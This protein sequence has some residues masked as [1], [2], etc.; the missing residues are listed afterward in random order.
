MC[1]NTSIKLSPKA[2]IFCEVNILLQIPGSTHYSIVMYFVTSTLK[3]GSL[4]QR[5]FDGDDEFRN[6]RL[7]L[8]PAVP[9]VCF[10]KQNNQAANIS[11]TLKPRF[12]PTNKNSGLLDSAAECRKYSLFTGKGRRLQLRAWFGVLG[13]KSCGIILSV[14][15][16][17]SLTCRVLVQNI[18]Y[19]RKFIIII[20]IFHLIRQRVL[21]DRLFLQVD[22][23]I[24]SSAVAN[25]VLGLVFGVVTTLVVDM[26]FLI[27]VSGHTCLLN[28]C[29]LWKR[30]ILHNLAMLMLKKRK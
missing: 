10:S 17:S 12:D 27:Q 25:G 28:F 4:L 2:N 30:R 7:K 11:C 29:F 14:I 5:F 21:M 22:V 9:K 8:I 26:A 1:L 15:H 18:D 16:S 23:D 20:I 6:S 13:S 19:Q 24:G 3:K